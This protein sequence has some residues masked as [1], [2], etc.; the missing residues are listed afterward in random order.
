M[1]FRSARPK[2]WPRRE[3]S[4][5]PRAFCFLCWGAVRRGRLGLLARAGPS[6]SPLFLA[7]R[8]SVL[9]GL[10]ARA[11]PPRA[12]PF[13][14]GSARGAGSTCEGGAIALPFRY[15][16]A[17]LR[18]RSPLALPPFL[19]ALLAALARY[20]SAYLRGRS[21]L[22]H[23]PFSRGPA[24]GARYVLGGAVRLER[25]LVGGPGREAPGQEVD[26][27]GLSEGGGAALGGFAL[28][29]DA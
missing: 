10:L 4:R 12:P 16:S 28:V 8:R 2:P 13:S 3:G 19:A 9:H 23:P 21:P 14:R 24:L 18:G 27:A 20:G 1:G 25:R 17:Y 15:G 11:F 7:V 29:G 26:G 5:F 6:R 22:A